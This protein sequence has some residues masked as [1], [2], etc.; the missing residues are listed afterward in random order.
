M[1]R[2]QYRI[3]G[4]LDW[5][6]NSGNALLVIANPTGSNK[7]ITVK[8]FEIQNRTVTAAAAGSVITPAATTLALCRSTVSGGTDVGLTKFDTNASAFPATVSV[9]TGGATSSNTVINRIFHLKQLNATSLSWFGRQQ[10]GP[11]RGLYQYQSK[12]SA[13]ENITVDEN[14]SVALICQTLNNSVPLRVTAILEVVGSPNRAYIASFFTQVLFQNQALFAVTNSSGSGQT[15]KI[16]SINVE[17]VGTYDSPYLQLVPLGSVNA[18]NLS[19]TTRSVSLI[20]MDTANPNPDSW[21][22]VY[23]N[24]CVLP[25]GGIPENY[26]ADGSTGSPRGFNYL[27]TKDFLGPVYRTFFPENVAQRVGG[28]PDVF[29]GRSQKYDDL[30][31]RFSTITIREGEA[32]GLVSGAETAVLTTAVGVSG[33]HCLEFGVQIDI[34]PKISPTLTLTGL[35]VDTEVRI[36]AEATTTELA[37]QEDIDTG[38]FSWVFDPEENPSIDIHIMSLGYQNIRITGLDLTLAD[39]TIPIQQQIDRQ[40]NNP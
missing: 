20:K 23:K 28:M 34:E 7:K 26:L 17:E 10:N 35:K 6:D 3:N 14:E 15:I 21:V 12:D 33:W 36:F 18:T 38:T 4:I 31:T 22:K 8:R 29:L 16:K 27:K 9:T 25:G 32:V 40:Y 13:V 24:V 37:G 2:Y 5:M 39:V 19:D 11:K 1:A 30:L